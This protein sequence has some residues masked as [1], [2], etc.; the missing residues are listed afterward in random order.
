M[1]HSMPL[2]LPDLQSP[3]DGI[4]PHPP[5]LNFWEDKR[6]LMLPGRGVFFWNTGGHSCLP[7]GPPILEYNRGLVLPRR[8]TVFRSITLRIMSWTTY[9]VRNSY[10]VLHF[11]YCV[12]FWYCGY[13]AKCTVIAEYWELKQSTESPRCLFP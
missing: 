3:S 12:L 2:P 8:G 7:G 6:R 4:I 13:F 9:V 10:C 11:P 5:M 1:F